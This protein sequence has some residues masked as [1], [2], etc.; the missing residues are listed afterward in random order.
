MVLFDIPDIRL[1]WTDDK[2]FLSQFNGGKIT[3]FKPYS[4]M[5]ACYK[6]IR[7]GLACLWAALRSDFVYSGSFWVPSGYHENAFYD[8]VRKE[9]GDIV[10]D[11]KLVS[12]FVHPKTNRESHLYRLNYRSMDR[13]LT[14][15]EVDKIQQVIRDKA[16]VQLGIELR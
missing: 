5:P 12:K 15:E 9:T 7:Y 6:D 11:V 4:K 1:F 2:R 3:K 16:P 8:L 13:T 14:N 10:E